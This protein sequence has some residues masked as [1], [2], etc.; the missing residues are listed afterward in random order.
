MTR[1]TGTIF[2]SSDLS[3]AYNQVP[4]TEDTQK[5]T[6]FIVGGRQYTYQVG[7]YG[8]KPLPSFFSKLMRYAFGP[9]IKRKQAITYI[10]D[11]LLQAKDKQEMFTIV[12]EYHSLLRKANLKAAPDKTMFFLRKVRFLG[13]VISKNGLS[14]IASRIDDI[15]NLKTPESKTEVLRVLG[16]MGFYHTYILNFHIDAKPLYDLTKDTTLFKWL[17]E[18]EKVFTD[19]KQRFCHDISNAFPSNDYPF[20]IHADSSNLG[21]GCVLIQDFPDRKR[22]ISANSRV[23]DK[24]EQKMSPQHRELC[25]IISAL[26]TYEFYVIGSPFPIYLYCDHRPILFLWSRRG[27]MS[28]RFFKYQVVITKFQ[29]LQIIYTE[30]KNLA[31]PDIL[32]RNVSLADAK[33]YQLEHKVIPKD[34]KFHINGKEVNYSVLHQDDKDASANDCYPIITQ[35]KGERRKLININ[36]E[37]DFSVDD[38]PDYINEHCNAIHSFSDCFR[39]GT[40]INQIKKLTSELT[41]EYDNHYYSEIE[42]IAEISD[43]REGYDDQDWLDLVEGNIENSLIEQ[44]ESAKADYIR[45]TKF[46][47]LIEPEA[48]QNIS[49]KDVHTDT[50]DLIAKVTDFAKNANLDTDNILE[51]QVNDSVINK[52]RD[53]LKLGKA[54]EKD[55]IIKQSKALQTYRNNFN[56]LFLENEYDLLC[57]SEPCEDGSFDV[58]ICAPLSLFIKIFEVAHTHELSGHRAESTTYN[59]VKRYFY[60]PGMF[61]WIEMLMLDCLSCQTNKSARKDLNEAPL[62]PWG[63]LEAIP[64]HTLHIDHKGPLRPLSK[65]NRFCLVIVDAFSRFIQVYPSKNA[66]ALETVNQLE[67]FITTF[68]IPQQIVHDNGNAFISNDF[69]H[70]TNEMGITLCPRT[71]Y[72][73]WT[74]GK[75]EV[76]NKHLTNYLRHFICKSGSNWSEY[77]SKFAF[78]HNTAVNYSTGYTPYEILFGTK[79]Q[80]PLSLKLGLLRDNQ[81]KCTSEYCS[82]LPPHSHSEETCNNKKIEKLL[83][84]RLSNEM[85]K[86]EN[87]FETIYSNTYT[88]CRQTTNKAH[89]YRN[90]FKLG[91]P[92]PE[93][94]KVLLENHSKGLLKSKKLQELRSGPYTVQRMLTNTTYEI[95]HD[96]TNE[97]KTVHRNHI[98]PYYPKEDKIQELVENYVVSDDTDDYYTQYNKHNISKSNAY[99]GAQHIAISQWPLVE[100]QPTINPNTTLQPPYNVEATPTKDSGLESLQTRADNTTHIQGTSSSNFLPPRISTP[101]P[102]QNM[103]SPNSP[104][105]ENFSTPPDNTSKFKATRKLF[106]QATHN[107]PTSSPYNPTSTASPNIS[108]LPDANEVLS[109]PQRNRKAPTFFGEPIPSD[110]LHKLKKK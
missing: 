82:N 44:L 48:F 17:P 99:R 13:H 83:Q 35:V 104:Q 101:Y 28:H 27:Q 65:G 107:S 49:E 54:P 2:T 43:D 106:P 92:I 40:Q 15:R 39:Y 75:V 23:F 69:V 51:E 108:N 19:L 12:K 93:G 79:P 105:Q 80:I 62:E 110:L 47:K 102:M 73:P 33:L 37:G 71:A 81:K 74:N 24:A 63:Q 9:L 50:L 7:F 109:R 8:L 78:S 66:E 6:S 25:G 77:T 85:L 88:K 32:S 90:R 20:H 42:E 58:R 94:R 103:Y 95:Q 64:L 22:M 45:R 21:T 70:Y 10:D 26:Q 56:L 91:K 1:I 98:V 18:H 36:D 4:L 87:T 60:W 38:A 52:V 41:G 30:G 68:G 61:K 5:V 96:K 84:N 97:K 100:T 16:M 53:W 76:Q 29:N 14:P 3:S 55:Y 72:S 11:T 86:R 34:I 46:K 89:K 59:R 31:F 57:Y 67:K